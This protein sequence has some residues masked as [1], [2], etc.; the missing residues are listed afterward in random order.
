MI[1][2][3]TK[4]F[5]VTAQSVPIGSYSLKETGANQSRFFLWSLGG[6][7]G[8]TSGRWLEFEVRGAIYRRHTGY[9]T[10]SNLPRRCGGWKKVGK[11]SELEWESEGWPITRS[12]LS[13]DGDSPLPTESG[14]CVNR[15]YVYKDSKNHP[16][17]NQSSQKTRLGCRMLIRE[18]KRK[19]G[20]KHRN[21]SLK[22][23]AWEQALR[24]IE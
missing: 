6:N 12:S 24:P 5:N 21:I 18:S 17:G 13:D 8:T 23:M 9:G 3:L 11:G 7:E 16:G 19:Q 14:G 10:C 22:M 4:R 1:D 2:T 20:I 15:P